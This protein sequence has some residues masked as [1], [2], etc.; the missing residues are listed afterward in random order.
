M[1]GRLRKF[2]AISL[3]GVIIVLTVLALFLRS[4][5]TDSLQQHHEAQN[6]LLA[7]VFVNSLEQR[8]LFEVLALSGEAFHYD[9]AVRH[10][11]Q[12]MITQV[13][14]LSITKIRIF[15]KKGMVVYS[16]DKT[17]IGSQPKASANLNRAIIGEVTS[18][19]RY[20]YSL[21]SF[22]GLVKDRDIFESYLPIMDKRGQVAGVMEL[23]ADVTDSVQRLQ[24]ETQR[25]VAVIVALISGMMTILFLIFFRTEKALKREEVEREGYMLRLEANKAKLEFRVMERTEDLDAARAYL[26]SII[27]GIADPVMV[28]GMDLRVLSKNRAA[29]QL[30]PDG[31]EPA[32]YRYCYQISHRQAQPC[33][34]GDHPCA[35][36]D[37]VSS[38]RASKLLHTHYDEEGHR[39]YAEITSTPLYSH[40]GEILGIIEVIHD[41]TEVFM[42][43]DRLVASEGRVRAIMDTVAD[44][45]LAIDSDGMVMDAN[46]SAE[47][48]L[49]YDHV[50][51]IGQ[52]AS[53]LLGLDEGVT[54]VP[55]GLNETIRKIAAHDHGVLEQ[56]IHSRSGKAIPAELWVGEAHLGNNCIYIAVLHDLTIR[57]GAEQELASTRQQYFHQEKMAA[58]GQLAAGILHEVGNPIAAI[59]GSL[60]AIHLETEESDIA[61]NAQVNE[62]LQMIE[63][64]VA[65]LAVITREIAEFASPRPSEMTLLDLNGLIRSTVNLMRYDHRLRHVDLNLDLD[66]M[67]PAITAVADQ[68]TQVIMNLIINAV[69]AC[70]GLER[71]AT[72]G[73]G[74]R[75]EDDRIIITVT[76]NG[77][78]MDEDTRRQ[79]TEAFFTTKPAGKGT[80]LGLSLC[81]SI[82]DRHHGRAEI[83]SAVGEGTTIRLSLPIEAD[84]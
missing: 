68:L 22:S 56:T 8:G 76:D 77:S 40:N 6:S 46:R 64:Q 51:M 30:I 69:D 3:V 45:I 35:F 9:M 49:G 14:D 18:Q 28:V 5:L 54:Q 43:K 66:P 80:G 24:H 39:F 20:S 53:S 47:D 78:G 10:L 82:L 19:L 63:Q 21:N 50:E 81:V 2:I 15:N 59:S 25:V 72:I 41:V 7:R 57:K 1:L 12:T 74:T 23:Y 11:D 60:Q 70:E 62:Y 84:L 13:Q 52:Q 71:R 42:A 38:G 16:H 73:I 27:D 26:Q 75:I 79:A 29:Q 65:R 48:L 58:I 4:I 44:A 55:F 36:K 33:R 31:A 37:V 83:I 17:E 32:S 61:P 34:G 67:L